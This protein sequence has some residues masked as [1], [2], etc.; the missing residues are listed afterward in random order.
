LS[1]SHMCSP[2]PAQTAVLNESDILW[3][4]Y[5]STSSSYVD[6]SQVLF[7]KTKDIRNEIHLGREAENE[8]SVGGD[9]S[10]NDYC[11]ILRVL[12]CLQIDSSSLFML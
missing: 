4:S 8:L 10:Q 12:I 9:G 5:P 3:P 7:S 11:M 2:S 1:S 6:N